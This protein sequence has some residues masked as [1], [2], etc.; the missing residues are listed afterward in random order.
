MIA[1]RSLSPVT[2]RLGLEESRN[3][4]ADSGWPRGNSSVVRDVSEALGA[5]D[6]HSSSSSGST[7]GKSEAGVRGLWGPTLRRVGLA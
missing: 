5:S 7:I 1:S 6:N 2:P 4:V 3:S